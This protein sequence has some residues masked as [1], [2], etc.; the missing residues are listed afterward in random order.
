MADD[1]RPVRGLR[2]GGPPPVPPAYNPVNVAP[3]DVSPP[4][5]PVYPWQSGDELF[6]IALNDAIR[7]GA[8]ISSAPP[9]PG[10]DGEFWWDDTD[11]GL[12]I[13]YNDGTSGQWVGIGSGS[14]TLNAP[15]R[16]ILNW[17]GY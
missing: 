12:Y 11:T 16:S 2:L 14:G 4:L 9:M 1:G 15:L 8:T 10:V 17:T 13:W 5:M 3:G 7:R 6:A